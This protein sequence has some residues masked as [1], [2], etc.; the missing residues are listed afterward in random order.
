MALLCLIT[1]L[2]L[3]QCPHYELKVTILEIP[4]DGHIFIV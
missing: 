1:Y 4:K 2:Q 3:K